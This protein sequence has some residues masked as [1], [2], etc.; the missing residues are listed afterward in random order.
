MNNSRKFAVVALSVSLVL[1]ALML[2]APASAT[3]N[4]ADK[5]SGS[6]V[7]SSSSADDVP[8]NRSLSFRLYTGN[9]IT[10][11]AKAHAPKIVIHHT[12]AP[13]PIASPTHVPTTNNQGQLFSY[14]ELES[15]WVSQGGNPA[16][17]A[18]AACIAEHE[19][20]GKSW[21][22]S[23]TDDWGLWQIHAGGYAMLN[24]QAN[25]RRAIAMS[26][27]G[28]NWS[29]WSTAGYC[30]AVTDS[31]GEKIVNTAKQFI[32]CPYVWGG[33]G[34]CNAGFDCSGL[35]YTSLHI[36]GDYNIPRVA[37]DQQAWAMS[38]S[39]NELQPG[40][41]VFYG[42]PAHHV[43]IYVGNGMTLQAPDW[44]MDVSYHPIDWAGQPSS[45]GR[46]TSL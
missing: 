37:A 27:N 31:I 41:L 28:T 15:L 16:H 40:D 4:V 30:V 24:P 5:F 1:S 18:H 6:T 23:P 44:G 11:I 12:A 32:G 25:A 14:S 34:P 7:T 17:K 42:Y 9:Y 29:P 20:G 38:I 21:V 13:A 43:A 36:L 8:I 22:I 3:P 45:Y 33:T 46:I 2:F 39:A 35:V 19:S 26:G 10:A